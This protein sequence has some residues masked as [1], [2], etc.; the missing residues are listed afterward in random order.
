M[1]SFLILSGLALWTLFVAM[2]SS[3]P[4]DPAE[5]P[6]RPEPQRHH[7]T[8]GNAAA[9][10]RPAA[11]APA[12]AGRLA[13]ARDEIEAAVITYQPAAV[14]VIRTWLLDADPE[15]RR[16]ARDG[17]VQLGESDA[18]PFLRH[19][20]SRLED[21]A[22]VASLHEA[23]DLLSLPAWSDTADARAAVAEIAGEF[24]H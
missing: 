23:A 8:A 9:R 21:P 2:T 20:A 4:K 10:V 17:L 22:E 16:A 14:K 24:S 3:R 7:R 13:T 19:A 5:P 1:K 15:I 12:D 6:P 11:K 18:I